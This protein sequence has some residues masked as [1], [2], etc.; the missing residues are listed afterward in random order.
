MAKNKIQFQKSI[1]I[2][3]F[4]QRYGD[5]ALCQQRLFQM[6]WPDGYCCPNCGHTHCCQL[7][8][9]AVYQCNQCHHQASVTAGTLFA[10]SKLPLNVWFLAIYLITQEK[11]GISAL[12]LSRQLGISYNATWRLKH[13][14]MQAMKERDDELPLTGFI[15]LDDAYWGGVRAGKPGRGAAGKRPFVAAVALNQAGHPL[16][17]RFSAVSGFK[18]Q[19]LTEWAKAHLKPES[20]VVS[21]GLACFRGI[22]AAEVE[23]LP[24]VTGGGPKSV[25]LPYF[26]WVNTMIS[27]VKNAMHGTYHA[28]S[29][30]HLPRYLS[31]FCFKFNHRFDLEAM[32][33]ALIFASIRTAP[34]PARLL[35]LAECRW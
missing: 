8:S 15:Q 30:K 32:I 13:K 6:R 10:Y 23:H 17:M 21:D 4:I 7:K 22:T 9:R 16:R 28:I 3:A 18:K 19:E 25:K 20:L 26:K 29:L 12:E 33:D 24:I 34:M 5:E 35:K 27:N 1:C 14:L 31:E 2:H 11:N